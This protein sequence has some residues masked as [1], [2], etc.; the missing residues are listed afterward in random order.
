[1]GNATPQWRGMD[2]QTRADAYSPSKA[3]PDGDLTPFIQRYIDESAK[4]YSAHPEFQTLRYGPKPANTLD[5]V[6]PTASG[7]VPLHVFIHGGYWQQLSKQDSFFAATQTLAQGYGYAAIDYTLTPDAR[8]SKIVAECVR[9]ITLLMD[10]AAN[11]GVDPK[12]IVLSGSSAGAQLAAMCCL[13]LPADK[14]PC[15]VVL[16]SGVYEL[17]PLL[18]TYVND[19]VGMDL[20]EAK[21][22]SPAL[23][24]LGDFPKT[25]VAWGV[26]ET[27]EFK[28]QSRYF[29]SLLQSAK[30]PVE[31]L[32]VDARNHFDIVFDL[33]NDSKLGRHTSALM[34]G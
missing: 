17:E 16:L 7:P 19:A 34:K 31:T 1:M 5:I 30:R 4:A 33:A 12:R 23:H 9:A 27:Q 26:Q 25:V 11:L 20:A 28:R 10:N 15:G 32:E 22:N 6:M 2:D 13:E 29:A 3:L 21:R 8:I 24:D 18:G 14:Q